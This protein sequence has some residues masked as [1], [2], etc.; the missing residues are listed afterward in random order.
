MNESTIDFINE[1]EYESDPFANVPEDVIEGQYPRSINAH[2]Y[3][4]M[5]ITIIKLFL[6]LAVLIVNIFL[7]IV[8]LRFRRLHA[9]RSNIYI[10]NMSILNIIYYLCSPLFYIIC[11]LF[12]AY[13]QA[14][15]LILQTQSTLLTLYTTFALT[16]G[17]D[18][19]LMVSKPQLM[20]RFQQRYKYVIFAIYILFFIEWIVAFIYSEVEHIARANSFTI[21]YVIYAAI[22][23]VLNILKRRMEIRLES[24][25]TEYAFIVS[26]IV[27]YCYLPI[28]LFHLL[29]LVPS[30]FV[31]KVLLYLEIIP[32]FIE[33]GHPILVIY[34]LWRLNKYFKMA[35]SKSFTRSVQSYE[36]DNLDVSENDQRNL[37]EFPLSSTPGEVHATQ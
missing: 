1:T 26:N 24:K 3:Y 21:F 31:D 11:H 36:D 34:M 18:W 30:A 8:I 16:M 15:V 37:Y 35:F 14:S 27:I 9:I 13:E 32:E 23:T 28:F 4:L 29:L 22:L 10:L 20:K 12:S 7:V 25:N 6:V 33:T 2:G 5:V 17:I 19:F